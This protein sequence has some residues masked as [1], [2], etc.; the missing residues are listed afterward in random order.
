MAPITPI[1]GRVLVVDD[2]AILAAYMQR[3]LTADGHDVVVAVSGRQALTEVRAHPP[4]LVMLDLSMPGM[5]G[6]EVCQQLKSDPS[7]R[8]L[9]VLV[10]TGRDPADARLGAWD[11]GA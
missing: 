5:D 6:L 4:D 1:R 2:D 8:L 7:T 3:L 10:L 11:A 9:P